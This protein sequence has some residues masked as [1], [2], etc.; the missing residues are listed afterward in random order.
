MTANT[1][2]SVGLPE[3]GMRVRFIGRPP[4]KRAFGIGHPGHEHWLLGGAE[5][6]IEPGGTG[7]PRHRCPDHS[8]APDCVCGDCGDSPG[9]IDQMDPWVVVQYRCACG[10]TTIGRCCSLPDEG[11]LWE[12]VEPVKEEA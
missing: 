10:E 12:R 2:A 11:T 1:R 6:P 4:G 8:E 7:Y 9:W 3:I 5:G